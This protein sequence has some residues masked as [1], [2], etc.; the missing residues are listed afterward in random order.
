MHNLEKGPQEIKRGTIRKNTS[1]SNTEKKENEKKDDKKIKYCEICSK[2]AE[3][4]CSDCE[5]KYYCCQEHF[6]YD[7]NYIH[8]FV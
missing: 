3:F 8:F 7:Y 2:E 5:L 4:C 1:G 6:M